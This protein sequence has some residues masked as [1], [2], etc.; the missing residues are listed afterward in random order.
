MAADNGQLWGPLVKALTRKIEVPKFEAGARP[1]ADGLRAILADSPDS[2]ALSGRRATDPPVVTGSMPAVALPPTSGAA[3]ASSDAC[4]DRIAAHLGAVTRQ[5][6]ERYLELHGDPKRPLARRLLAL[7]LVPDGAHPTGAALWWLAVARGWVTPE[8]IAE[9]LRSCPGV[10]RVRDGHGTFADH[11]LEDEAA[12]YKEVRAAATQALESGTRLADVLVASGRLD[13]GRAAD[14][15]AAFFGLPRIRK[16]RLVPA[17]D[18]AGTVTLELARAFDIVPM[19]DAGD[20]GVVVLLCHDDPGPVLAESLKRLT[21]RET[22]VVIEV[23][24]RIAEAQAAWEEAIQQARQE[25]RPAK[26]S[27]R[28]TARVR[29][30]ERAKGAGFRLDQDA[31][32][33][34]SS[35]PE[36][37]RMLM[38]RSTSVG[39]TDI[40]LEPQG[41]RMRVRFRLDGILYDVA[42]LRL[43]FGEEVLSRIKVMAEMDITER[44]KPQDGHLQLE[45][46]DSRFDFRIATVPTSQGERMSVRITAGAR[47]IP[48]LGQLGLEDEEFAILHDF[49][50]RSH[51]IVLACGPVGAGKTTTLYACLGEVD[52]AQKNIMTIEDPV[53]IELPNVSQVPVNYKIGIDFSQGLR[54]LLR[55]D[56][57][58][59]LVGEVRDEETAKVAVRAS[60]TGLLVFSTIHANSAPGAITTLYNFNIP[61]FLISSSLV[62]VVAQRLVRTICDLCREAYQP[63]AQWLET[64]G[65]PAA[66]AVGAPPAPKPKGKKGASPPPPPPAAEGHRYERGRGCDQCYGTGYQGRTAIFEI[67][68]VREDIRTAISDRAPESTLRQLAVAGG[69]RTLA[70]RGKA[71]VLAGRTTVEEYMRVLHQ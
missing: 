34:V 16:G 69:M 60:L 25:V 50:H 48:H 10:P 38:E 40:H 14:L 43:G 39:A 22:V 55:Q 47:E 6:V 53:E 12:P 26:A 5:Q 19:V 32:V 45:L 36:M 57:N 21:G 62:G 11:L 44:R 64:L 13:E 1:N 68:E 46:N 28:P 63:D 9:V 18:L 54:A 20:P 37:A 70:D 4:I 67:L 23:A 42:S 66:R 27:G 71:K 33:G 8:V 58:I 52:S 29:P 59:I 35:P 51:G 17:V 31:F 7:G 15:N 56:P 3:V 49:A 41:D 30:G 65:L 24:S 2:S 61:P